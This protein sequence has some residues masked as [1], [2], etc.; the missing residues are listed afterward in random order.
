MVQE[1]FELEVDFLHKLSNNYK[2]IWIGPEEYKR[3]K[4]KFPIQHYTVSGKV[5][6]VLANVSP[7]CVI[8][9]YKWSQYSSKF[10]D[11]VAHPWFTNHEAFLS[12]RGFELRGLPS[13]AVP[14]DPVIATALDMP[15]L[16]HSIIAAGVLGLPGL[17]RLAA[18]EY[19]SNWRNFFC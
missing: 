6:L 19:P 3:T 8:H 16:T 5:A 2:K 17:F 18:D 12:E 1:L 14:L 10:F 13:D 4:H 15:F 11:E 9:S 7:C